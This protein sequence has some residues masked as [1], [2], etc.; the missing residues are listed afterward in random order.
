MSEVFNLDRETNLK[1]RIDPT[2]R[3]WEVHGKR[4]SALY[5]ARPNPDREDAV[6]PKLFAGDWTKPGLLLEKIDLYLERAWDTSDKAVAKT[7]RLKAESE[8][9][10]L[11]REKAR[12]EEEAAAALGAEPPA[13]AAEMIAEAESMVTDAVGTA[14]ELPVKTEEVPDI[15]EDM[16]PEQKEDAIM[17]AVNA[18]NAEIAS[19]SQAK[20]IAIQTQE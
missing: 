4:G 20:R 16:T 15:A 12:E 1:A 9:T 19:K 17:R 18:E 2:G 3:K 6:I 10:K 13:S 7:A 5:Y 8:A 14:D 11:L